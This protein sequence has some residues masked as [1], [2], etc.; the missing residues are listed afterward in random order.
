VK[1]KET[2]LDVEVVAPPGDVSPALVLV[3]T[4]V[5]NSFISV[6]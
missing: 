6:F 5:S 4:K 3:A 1:A 2:I